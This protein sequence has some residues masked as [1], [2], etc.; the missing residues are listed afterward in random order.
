MYTL[1]EN[2]TT[3]SGGETEWIN[4]SFYSTNTYIPREENCCAL[5]A[6]TLRFI[7][8]NTRGYFNDS[9][10]PMNATSFYNEIKNYLYSHPELRWNPDSSTSMP[11]ETIQAL[12]SNNRF[13]VN[14]KPIFGEVVYTKKLSDV[15]LYLND[16]NNQK[17]VKAVILRN[18]KGKDHIATISKID[19]NVIRFYGYNEINN[20]YNGG[21]TYYNSVLNKDGIPKKGKDCNNQYYQIIGFLLEYLE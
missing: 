16:P 1:A 17:T 2:M 5:Y 4:E 15:Q 13:Y 18:P 12:A 11:I 6:L 8:M 21:D 9:H 7:E 20:N 19:N 3:R 14:N 10:C